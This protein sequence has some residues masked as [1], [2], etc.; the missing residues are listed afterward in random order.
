[1]VCKGVSEIEF[2]IL[3][4]LVSSCHQAVNFFLKSH[5]T[6]PESGG[7]SKPDAKG[8]HGS[9]QFGRQAPE[10]WTG[11]NKQHEMDEEVCNNTIKMV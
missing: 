3:G 4:W 7:R 9:P 6:V 1:M 8:T 11:C 2:T 10:G 5:D